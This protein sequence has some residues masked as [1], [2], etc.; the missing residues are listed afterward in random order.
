[1][2]VTSTLRMQ[3]DAAGFVKTAAQLAQ[4]VDADVKRLNELKAALKDT[5]GTDRL[6]GN[7]QKLGASAQHIEGVKRALEEQKQE[8]GVLG[9]AWDKLTKEQKA[10]L[11]AVES[12]A[13]QVVR[14]EINEEKRLTTEAGRQAE[15]RT[16]DLK[17]EAERASD[18]KARMLRDSERQAKREQEILANIRRQEARD[19]T[20]ASEI[21]ARDAKRQA[22]EEIRDAKRSADA[23]IRESV[24]AAAA[25]KRERDREFAD[26]QRHE[27]AIHHAQRR[28]GLGHAA[29]QGVAGYASA[30][31]VISGGE[32]VL[33]KGSELQTEKLL[34]RNAGISPTEVVRI[35]DQALR[36]SAIVGNVSQTKVMETAKELRSMIADPAELGKVLDPIIRAKSVLDG[37]DTTG[38]SSEGIAQLLKAGELVGAAKDPER[39]TKLIDGWVKVMQVSGKTVNP[40]Q[41]FEFVKYSKTAGATLSD[42]FLTT[43]GPSILQELGGSTTGNDIAMMSKTIANGFGKNHTSMREA[44][45]I[46]LI[47]PG[48]IDYLKTGEAKGLKPGTEHAVAGDKLFQTDP[49]KWVYEVLLPLMKTAGIKSQEDQLS[50]VQRTFTGTSADFIAK[51][52]TQRQAYDT[53]AENY[54]NAAGL[55]AVGNNA[56]SAAVG[57]SSLNTAIGNLAGNVSEPVMAPIGTALTWLGGRI[58]SLAEIAKDHPIAAPAIGGTVGAAALAGSGYLSW[59]AITGFGMTAARTQITAAEMQLAAAEKAAGGTAVKV[60]EDAAGGVGVAGMT[61][62]GLAASVAGVAA[63]IALAI[64]AGKYEQHRAEETAKTFNTPEAKALPDLGEQ[65]F[66][67]RLWGTLP[68][69]ADGG[70]VRGPGGSRDDRVPVRLSHGEMVINASATARHR[71]ILEAINSGNIS[72]GSIGGSGGTTRVAL[73]TDS[74]ST[75]ALREAIGAGTYDAM[76]RIKAEDGSDGTGGGTASLRFGRDA[77]G[78]YRDTPAGRATGGSGANAYGVGTGGSYAIGG[79]DGSGTTQD[80]GSGFTSGMRARNLGNIGYFR[81][82]HAGV[83][84][85][86]GPSNSRDVDHSIALYAT[87]EDGIRAAARLALK[88]Y[89]SGMR[90]TA[91]LIA[92]KGGWTPGALGPGASVNIAKAMGLS[93]QDDL[94]LNDPKQMH[95]FLRGLAMQEHG[96]AGAY[97]SDAIIDRALSG[98]GP[99]AGTTGTGT[100]GKGDAAG[101]ALGMQ[102]AGERQSAQALGHVMH[103]GKWCADFMNGV[104]QKAGGRGTASAMADSFS[105]WGKA[106]STG[107]AKRGDVILENS[108]AGT[109]VHHVG[110]ATGNIRRDA[111][112]NVTAVEMISGNYGHMVK[113]NWERTGI[114]AGMRRGDV[115]ADAQRAAEQAVLPQKPPA[116]AS[117]VPPEAGTAGINM[118]VSGLEELREAHHHVDAIHRKVAGMGNMRIA[119]KVN[120]EG[121]SRPGA[122]RTA[123]N[124][125]YASDGRGWT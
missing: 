27:E 87:Q 55:A 21:I 124:G 112:G 48:D 118:K 1:M 85:L 28:G 3:L 114:I 54:G 70:I 30:H 51:T 47:N 34:M 50:F 98:G 44:A 96:S 103:A 109:R 5:G 7:L 12:T 102:G 111:N 33:E 26:Q 105:K 45:R 121:G 20:R 72:T 108:G 42:R 40:E 13:I 59:K 73:A 37:M 94:R 77:S 10:S 25:E 119:A 89:E 74:S 17:R 52:I 23:R 24:R 86:V 95:K 61:L 78:S 65:T 80:S 101:I 56:S 6:Q 122:L 8:L 91:S 39:L 125:G 88:K 81:G 2:I 79:G 110:M 22:D 92:G 66:L 71:S 116:G 69:H 76:R 18:A 53:H 58:N 57:L 93:N 35:T 46:G 75:S 97:Y 36:L 41:I 120:S 90:N 100:V 99:L 29:A 32:R 31:G 123:L 60:A 9:V 64:V 106:V 63:P 38:A 11:R 84:G 49:D 62:G 83:N 43:V 14:S 115:G 15:I 117:A 4:A 104:I 19:A 68:G 113:K 82:M 67:Q 107:D 16:A